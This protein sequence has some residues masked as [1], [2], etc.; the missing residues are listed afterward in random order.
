[1]F[2]VYL[3]AFIATLALTFRAA[4]AGRYGHATAYALA[5]AV[6]GSFLLPWYPD[7]AKSAVANT[8]SGLFGL[9]SV[10]ILAAVLAAFW[11]GATR[12]HPL[13][14]LLKPS[15]KKEA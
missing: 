8:L 2:F 3:L 11:L 5:A 15:V 6:L 7:Y 4:W 9:Q 14:P 1:M 10:A 13:R 12:L